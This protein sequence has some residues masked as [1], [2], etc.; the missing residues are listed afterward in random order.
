MTRILTALSLALL[1][2]F[3]AQA[4]R[5]PYMIDSIQ[6]RLATLT[7]ATDSLKAYL[8]ILD[9][10]AADLDARVKISKKVYETAA[11]AGDTVTMI[12]SLTYRANAAM[13]D[14]VELKA[15]KAQLKSLSPS[16]RRKE[17]ELFA[18]MLLARN[19][20]KY[21]E[22]SSREELSQL[23][24]QSLLSADGDY[25]RLLSL[26][27]ACVALSAH[28][29]GPLLEDYF[30]RLIQLVD[31]MN[32]PMGSVRNLVYN[33]AAM[34]YAGNRNSTKAVEMN[35]KLL[36]IVDSLTDSYARRGRMYRR[37][38]RNRYLFYRRMLINHDALSPAEVESYHRAIHILAKENKDIQDDIR[39]NPLAHACYLVTNGDYKE[40]IAAFKK[41]SGL[42]ENAPFLYC[43][44]SNIFDAAEKSGDR[45]EQ[46][47]ASV[48]LNNLLQS[49]IKNK[50]EERY[51]ELQIMYD[52]ND[53]KARTLESEEER[54]LVRI[55]AS[56]LVVG[57]TIGGF[58]LLLVFLL[59]LLSRNRKMRKLSKELKS[60][61]DRLREERNELRG[62]QNELIE[63]RDMAK[64]A[65]RA[66]AEFI[67]NISHEIKTPLSAVV[68]YSRL[69]V[70]CIPDEQHR[71]LKKFA[72]IID[73]NTR[74]VLTLIDDLLD[75]SSL[76]HGNM[77]ISIAGISVHKLCT[78][79][80]GSVFENMSTGTPDVKLIF[81]PSDKADIVINT[82]S[83]RVVQILMNLLS[84]A[85]KF[86]ERGK[87]IVDYDCDT[88]TRKITFSVTD[89]GCGIPEGREEDI[90]V[91]FNRSNSNT[92]GV[93]LGL[94]ISRLLARLLN[95]DLA[96]D[97]SYREGARFLLVIPM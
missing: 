77:G 76:E 17:A 96:V 37:L 15:V 86:T 57:I 34:V 10:S 31:G 35:K 6:T 73:L 54:R 27:S 26:Y 58:V 67:D 22:G 40:A 42:K 59:V 33:S 25:P 66:K 88:E 9:L 97:P 62:T 16:L 46:L 14:S 43:I 68:E 5:R 38:D 92:P 63:A 47:A 24:Q 1:M 81:N 50:T 32:L 85:S 11:H 71:Y 53:L 87:I 29:T 52:V 13:N 36:N 83:K 82:D 55:R 7:T 75:A 41:A 78:V 51:R 69:I 95:G 74:L 89:T 8:D 79:A 49:Q 91:R 80:M 19:R 4:D 56:R 39:Y 18:D 44:Y 20:L 90:F 60:T 23:M 93:G 48:Q 2:A 45:S 72:D 28:T 94:Y 21:N 3:T 65:E 30:E 61:A 84:N 70:D 64:S 12:E